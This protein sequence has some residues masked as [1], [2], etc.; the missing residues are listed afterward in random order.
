[1]KVFE[2]RDAGLFEETLTQIK[3][4]YNISD[5]NDALHVLCEISQSFMEGMMKGLEITGRRVHPTKRDYWQVYNYSE[6]FQRDA[7]RKRL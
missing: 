6:H 1:M 2:V 4:Y 3:G 7:V 5:T